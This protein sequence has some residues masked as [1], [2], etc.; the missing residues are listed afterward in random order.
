MI[1]KFIEFI[2]ED[3]NFG[4]ADA[5]RMDTIDDFLEQFKN[6]EDLNIEEP[7]NYLLLDPYADEGYEYQTYIQNNLENNEIIFYEGW[8]KLCWKAL[9]KRKSYK[10]LSKTEALDKFI[11]ERV[12]IIARECNLIIKDVSYYWSEQYDDTDKDVSG[13]ILKIIFGIKS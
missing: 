13:Y 10:G 12:P 1:T 5:S 2:N 9:Y 3:F 4:I 6:D 8:S 11:A 7:D